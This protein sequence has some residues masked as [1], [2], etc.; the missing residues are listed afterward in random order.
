MARLLVYETETF[1][2]VKVYKM[3]DVTSIFIRD[4]MVRIC[5]V[6][7]EV[8]SFPISTFSVITID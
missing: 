6:Y 8:S 1:N 7:G 2:E 4:G 5:T 3:E